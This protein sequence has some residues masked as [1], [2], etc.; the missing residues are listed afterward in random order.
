LKDRCATAVCLLDVIEHLPEPIA[1]LAEARRVVAKHG[2]VVVTVPAHEWLWS[3]TDEALGHYRR[4]TMRALRADL[5]QAQLRP[6]WM[7]HAFSWCV[8]PV[9]LVRKAR[10]SS[11]AELGI[12]PSPPAVTWAADRLNGVERTVL[13]WAPIP[14]G[15]S[16]VAAAARA[17]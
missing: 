16:I 2:V 9:W 8:P 7:S 15:T 14:F 5:A 1:G 4:Y 3:A 6:L 12:E 11:S 17:V 10:R 13:R